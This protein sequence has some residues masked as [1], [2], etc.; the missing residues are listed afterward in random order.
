M[1]LQ[2][3]RS[4]YPEGDGTMSSSFSYEADEPVEPEV[5]ASDDLEDESHAA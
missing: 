4:L 1:E 5:E 3:Y 2:D